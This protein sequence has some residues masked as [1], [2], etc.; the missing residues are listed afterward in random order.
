MNIRRKKSTLTEVKVAVVGAHGVGKTGIT[1]KIPEKIVKQLNFFMS[2][3]NE[4][5]FQH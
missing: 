2:E 4:L 5:N 1:T 3:L